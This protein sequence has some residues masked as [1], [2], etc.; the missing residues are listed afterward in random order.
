[1]K[2]LEQHRLTDQLLSFENTGTLHE[3]ESY[4]TDFHEQRTAFEEWI[5]TV[6]NISSGP[7]SPIKID[8]REPASLV[9]VF[10]RF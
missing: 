6:R 5:E 8:S 9:A 2:N 10:L 7:L 4:P 3:W 1:M